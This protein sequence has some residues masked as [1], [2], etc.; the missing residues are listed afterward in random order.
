MAGVGKSQKIS[1]FIIHRSKHILI[2]VLAFIA[3]ASIGLKNIGFD[4]D[5]KKFLSEA[6]QASLDEFT[7]TYTKD[8]TIMIVVSARIGTL[9]T[10]QNLKSIE[11]LTHAAWKLPNVLR[12][13]SLSNF[14]NT[15]S[16]DDDLVVKDLVKNADQLTSSQIHEIQNIATTDP[17]LRRRLVSENGQHAVVLINFN[18]SEK[19]FEKLDASVAAAR[20]LAE[21]ISK[22]NLGVHLRVTGGAVISWG[23]RDIAISDMKQ[24]IPLMNLFL[25]LV[26]WFFLRTIKGVLLVFTIIS[27]SILVTLGLCGWSHT[28]ISTISAM[29]P[30]IIMTLAV[31]DSVHVLI[32]FQ[33][34]LVAGL[35]KVEAIKNSLEHNIKPM[36]LTCLTTF[37]G[38]ITMNFSD[39]PNYREFGNIV[40]VGILFAFTFTCTLLPGL[41]LAI[42]SQSWGQYRLARSKTLSKKI[43]NLRWL[44][45]WVVRRRK[46][47][48]S[49]WIAGFVFLGLMIP[50]N[51]IDED[52]MKLV[53]PGHPLREDIE[54]VSD[55]VVGFHTMQYNIKGD[56]PDR[57]K[58]P[59]YLKFLEKF[60]DWLMA[61]KTQV[62]QVVSLA[63]VIK[64]LNQVMHNGTA[65]FYSI[66]E[67]QKLVAQYLL[68]YELAL[69]QGLDLTNMINVDKSAS[70]M[71]VT[72]HNLTN[73]EMLAFADRATEWVDKNA[74]PFITSAKD[75]GATLAF[76]KVTMENIFSMIEGELITIAAICLLMA[77]LFR[78]ARVGL[79]SILPNFMP[80]FCGLGLWGLTYQEVGMAVSSVF[81][82]TLGIAIDDTIHFL[83]HYMEARR[84]RGL[85]NH[86]A[87]LKSFEESAP[88]VL[89]T[90][91]ILMAG[92][93]VT[94]FSELNMNVHFAVLT[95]WIF[96]FAMLGDY[97]LLGPLLLLFDRREYK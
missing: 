33:R 43:L 60:S 66:P 10:P 63:D 88:A 29:A 76:S 39:S 93:G 92:F 89:A 5:Y 57:V 6:E 51:R 24:N 77:I 40:S 71:I 50:K 38:F 42:P 62:Q 70:R 87:L 26:L 47:C 49:L 79:I 94:S 84:D 72:L 25:F 69:P 81:G 58:D 64:N 59:A 35:T 82:L 30:T 53:R 90:S 97:F 23:V 61:Q 11:K 31:A 19:E 96:F 83:N 78:P 34:Y 85:S 48:L 44:G 75:A 9:F 86:E 15:Q 95:V 16:K 52:F 73:T 12:V 74:P 65:K 3:L 18:I 1:N 32:S 28:A 36:F 91:L 80:A 14:Q 54:F 56:G 37:V 8:M 4:S 55:H 13:D 20:V 2:G 27:S 7:N 17:R 67:N 22:E 21:Q 45:E 68:L 41:L 46:L